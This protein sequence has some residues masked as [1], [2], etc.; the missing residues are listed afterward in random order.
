MFWVRSYNIQVLEFQ[1]MHKY[2]HI[3]PENVSFTFKNFFPL[4]ICMPVIRGAAEQAEMFPTV[5][6]NHFA[7]TI[8]NN[9][10]LFSKFRHAAMIRLY[11]SYAAALFMESC[12]MS[13]WFSV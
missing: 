4:T 5:C 9:N 3:N 8:V 10:M 13:C 2:S 11:Y 12:Q 1:L 6:T 7:R